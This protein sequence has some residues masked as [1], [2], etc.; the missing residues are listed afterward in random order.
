MLGDPFDLGR[1]APVLGFVWGFPNTG[2]PPLFGWVSEGRSTLVWGP[3]EGVPEG[4]SAPVRGFSS[5]GP[6]QL[7][8]FT[9]VGPLLSGDFLRSGAV[10][11]CS[12]TSPVAV[13]LFGH[14]LRDGPAL[15]RRLLRGSPQARSIPCSG[16]CSG[17]H[18][19]WSPSTCSG[20]S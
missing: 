6:P 20:S 5:R 9:R 10:R 14:F 17:F 1:S 16:T 8:D 4:R 15:V 13:H 3:V 2:G 7:G 12:G 11:P 18:E 19:E